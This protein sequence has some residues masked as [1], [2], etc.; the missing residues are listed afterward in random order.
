MLI[1]KTEL[2]KTRIYTSGSYQQK[3]AHETSYLLAQKTAEAKEP[4]KTLILC[5]LTGNRSLI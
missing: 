4:C 5:V 1:S 3:A 2:V